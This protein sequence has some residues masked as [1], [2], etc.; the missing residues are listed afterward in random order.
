MDMQTEHQIAVF[1]AD[2][3]VTPPPPRFPGVW[4]SIAWILFYFAM[5]IV[6]GIVVMALV[7]ALDPKLLASFTGGGLDEAGLLAK[8]GLPL[9]VSVLLSGLITLAVLW[10]HLR[11]GARH[12]QIGLFARSRFSTM[13]TVVLGVGLILAT[14]LISYL[15]SAYVVPGKELQAG[16]NQLIAGIPKTPLNHVILFL[17]IAVVAPIL[18]ELLFRGYLQSALMHRMKPWAAI[19]LASAVFG[20]VHL[21]PLAFPMLAMLGAVFGYLYHKTG[22][23]KVNMALHVINNGAAYV[24]MAL[25]LSTGA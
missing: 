10:L 13:H 17:A 16:V 22:S 9:I 7:V 2:G 21:Q 14:I 20:I 6:C 8:F 24:L 11:K 3:P 1:D 18:E 25:G 5:Q 15:Y 23:L 4:I 12:Q 19:A